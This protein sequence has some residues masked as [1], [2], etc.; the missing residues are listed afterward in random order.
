[1]MHSY[2]WLIVAAGAL[3][4]CVGIGA[5]FGARIVVL[6]GAVL[7]GAALVRRP[8]GRSRCSLSNS[9]T[10]CWSGRRRPPSSRR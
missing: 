1:M 9:A 6:T 7:L 10:A 4:G 5:M 2:R 3:M 8:A